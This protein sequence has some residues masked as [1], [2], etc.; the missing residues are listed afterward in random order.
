M[1]Y[2]VYF[3]FDGCLRHNWF[4]GYTKKAI[5]EKLKVEYPGCEI[6]EFERRCF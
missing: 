2:I 4:N 3:M 6:V 1:N 5:K